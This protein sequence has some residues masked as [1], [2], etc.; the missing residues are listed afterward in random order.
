MMSLKTFAVWLLPPLTVVAVGAI[1]STRNR[2]T[3]ASSAVSS[4]NDNS[5]PR[6]LAHVHVGIAPMDFESYVGAAS[7]IALVRILDQHACMPSA[8][9]PYTEYTAHVMYALK[10]AADKTIHVRVGGGSFENMDVLVDKA[11]AFA[12]GERVLLFLEHFRTASEDSYSVLGLSD[13]VYR[14][15]SWTHDDLGTVSGRHARPGTPMIDF[16]GRIVT[17]AAGHETKDR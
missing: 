1:D 3:A 2:D 16:L 9:L 5:A 4:S 14:V 7:D 17:E 10:G 13:G 15:Q 6:A 8:G 11:P 12:A